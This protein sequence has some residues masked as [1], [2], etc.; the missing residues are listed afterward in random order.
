MVI[1]EQ[2]MCSGGDVC[3]GVVARSDCGSGSGSAEGHSLDDFAA[4]VREL[5]PSSPVFGNY[6][7][8]LFAFLRGNVLRIIIC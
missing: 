5:D 1:S 7:R 3:V 4:D 8:F 2:G 6:T